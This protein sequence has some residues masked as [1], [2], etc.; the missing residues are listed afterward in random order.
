M[1]RLAAEMPQAPASLFWHQ[2]KNEPVKD[3]ELRAAA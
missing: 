2:W 3:P 1:A